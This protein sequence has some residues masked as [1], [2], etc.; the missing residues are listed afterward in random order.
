MKQ[1]TRYEAYPSKR[2]EGYCVGFT[3]IA[4]NGRSG[5]IDTVVPL[6]ECTGKIDEEIVELGAKRLEESIQNMYNQLVQLNPLVGT[7]M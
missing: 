1:L 3:V 2:P 6:D 4:E 5:Y 7:I